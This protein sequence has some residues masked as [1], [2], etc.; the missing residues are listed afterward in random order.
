MTYDEELKRYDQTIQIIDLDCW[1]K[2]NRGD[3]HG[4]MD[5]S[6]DARE[7]EAEKRGFMKGYALAMEERKML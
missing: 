6:A 3:R 1:S 2:F 5:C 4:V 7:T